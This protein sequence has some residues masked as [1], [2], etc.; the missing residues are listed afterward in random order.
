MNHILDKVVT[1]IFSSF[2]SDEKGIVLSVTRFLGNFNY[3]IGY[4]MLF[5]AMM[6]I[7]FTKNTRFD[8]LKIKLQSK[9]KKSATAI[10]YSFITFL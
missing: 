2:R 10:G 8:D 1:P 6:A 4:F 5:F 3:Y 7:L 9:D